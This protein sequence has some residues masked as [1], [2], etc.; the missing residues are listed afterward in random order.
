MKKNNPFSKY[1]P[2]VCFC[3]TLLAMLSYSFYGNNALLSAIS[4]LFFAIGSIGFIGIAL[5]EI[6]TSKFDSF[7]KIGW[8]AIIFIIPI[9]IFFYYLVEQKKA[10]E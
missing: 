4:L 6:W 5:V 7:G 3:L 10:L 2:I 8:T 1:G 9:S